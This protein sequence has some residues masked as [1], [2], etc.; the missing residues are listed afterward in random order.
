MRSPICMSF[1]GSRT[2][3]RQLFRLS[4]ITDLYTEREQTFL[5]FAIYHLGFIAK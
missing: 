2:K 1:R 5:P 3:E 4:A